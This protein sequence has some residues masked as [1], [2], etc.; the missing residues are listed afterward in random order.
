[1][2]QQLRRTV[3]LSSLAFAAWFSSPVWSQSGD[4]ASYFGF[5]GMEVLKIDRGAGPIIVADV[6]GDGRN[7]L[8]VVNNFKSRIEVHYQRDRLLEED[9]APVQ[10][11]DLPPSRR[12]RG[13][14]IS[15]SH[16]I[17]AITAH[18]VNGDGLLDFVFAGRPDEIVFVMQSKPGTFEIGRRTRVRGLQANRNGMAVKDVIGDERP[19]LLALVEGKVRVWTMTGD[20]LEQKQ[21]LVAEIVEDMPEEERRPGSAIPAPDPRAGGTSPAAPG[22]PRKTWSIGGYVRDEAERPIPGAEVRAVIAEDPLRPVRTDQRGWYEVTVPVPQGVLECFAEGYLPQVGFV[23]GRSDGTQEFS[24]EGEG[25]WRRDFKLAVAAS[26]RGRVMDESLGPVA[27]ATVY[28][29]EPAH[30]LLDRAHGG[31]VVRSGKDGFFLFHGVPAGTWDVGV[32][33]EGF[34]PAMEKDVAVP[35]RGSVQRDVVL[36]PGRRMLVTVIGGSGHTDV[37][38]ADSRLRGRLLPPGGLH[39]LATGLVGREFIGLPAYWLAE[40]GHETDAS[41]ITRSHAEFPGLGPGAVGVAAQHSG[42]LTEPGLGSVLVSTP[43]K[44]ELRLLQAGQVWIEAFDAATQQPIRPS[45]ARETQGV[46]GRFPLDLDAYVEVPRDERTHVLH[47]ELEG[48]EPAQVAVP[49]ELPAKVRVD[50]QPVAEGETGEFLLEVEPAFTAGSPPS[51]ATPRGGPCGSGRCRSPTGR[52]AGG[53]RRCP[54]G[55]GR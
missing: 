21:D 15:V 13:E 29:I 16:Q 2:Q 52:G 18:D 17:L 33:A 30:V 45:V 12:F 28:V 22:P 49:R 46:A 23:N 42:W 9:E 37:L 50:M 24:C 31:N 32:R 8:V 39:A 35:E 54:S 36:K 44:L 26:L 38:V 43:E 40:I 1:M 10:V 3:L 53:S 7:D 55:R 47:F 48:Y 6:D 51:G 25:P 14:T 19:E 34:V 20:I 11:N 5:S 4:L 27:G 41:G